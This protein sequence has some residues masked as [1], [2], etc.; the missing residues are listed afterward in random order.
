MVNTGI[1]IYADDSTL[2]IIY[3]DPLQ[4]REMLEEKMPNDI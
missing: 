4:A 2:F 1:R 3:D